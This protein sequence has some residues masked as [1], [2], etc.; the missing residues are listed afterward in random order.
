[1]EKNETE[2]TFDHG[3]A[4]VSD[5]ITLISEIEHLR[6]HAIRSAASALGEEESDD[7]E[8]TRY[9]ILAKRA[10]D[11]RREYMRKHFGEIKDSD[12]CLCKT[13][14]CLRQLAY[15]VCEGNV[16]ELK[17]IDDL[18]DDVWGTALDMDLSDCIACRSD[19]N[20]FS[21]LGKVAT[22]HTHTSD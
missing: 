15:E 5:K 13:A 11:I 4:S 17:E 12:W 7:S 18:V 10:Q 19:R 9:L 20:A 21:D 3:K 22:S 8:S 1:M 14:A 6:R 2:K 16:E